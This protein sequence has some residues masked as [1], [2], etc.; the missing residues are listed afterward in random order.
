[1]TQIF[2]R[3]MKKNKYAILYVGDGASVSRIE[4]EKNVYATSGR[5]VRTDHPEGLVLNL[6]AVNELGIEVE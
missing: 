2:A 4:T 6:A 5:H 1:M 3:K